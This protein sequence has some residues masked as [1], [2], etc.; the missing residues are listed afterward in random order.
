V[1]NQRGE[2]IAV[3]SRA[4][5]ARF[6]KLAVGGAHAGRDGLEAAVAA[7]WQTQ[8]DGWGE[9]PPAA[10]LD[11]PRQ[12]RPQR[13]H[14]RRAQ[15][16]AVQRP[17]ERRQREAERD[18]VERQPLPRV[19]RVGVLGRHVGHHPCVLGHP[20]AP[21]RGPDQAA[22]VA[23]RLAGH[24]R[25][26]GRRQPRHVVGDPDEIARERGRLTEHDAAR[27]LRVGHEVGEPGAEPDLDDVAL[28]AQRLDER[29]RVAADPVQVVEQ[30]QAAGRGGKSS[31]WD[32][33]SASLY[34]PT[35]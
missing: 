25:E 9:Q 2:H 30:R 7:R 12:Q 13:A 23:V 19:P 17:R 8:Q 10:F 1:V 5:P 20:R 35:G 3:L 18:V 26:R 24:R 16:G 34:G 21:E 4:A 27:Q 28:V 31:G 22:P 11:R 33:G 6:E 15:V 32:R 29:L 14:D